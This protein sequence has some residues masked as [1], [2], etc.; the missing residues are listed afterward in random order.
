MLERPQTLAHPG[1]QWAPLGRGED[2]GQEVAEPGAGSPWAVAVDVKG[3]AHLAHGCLKL[4]VEAA[5]LGARRFLES[6]EKGPV[7]LARTA[8]RAGHFVVGAEMPAR[9]HAAAMCFSSH[10][11]A[12]LMSSAI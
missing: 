2:L 6:L 4:L 7:N 1:F 10:A 8:I 11:R 9:F 3:D 12:A 5:Q